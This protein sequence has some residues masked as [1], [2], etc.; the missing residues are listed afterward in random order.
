MY[1]A[2]KISQA[3]KNAAWQKNSSVIGRMS[4]SMAVMVV[5]GEAGSS[6]EPT[7]L[8]TKRVEILSQA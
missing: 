5:A 8:R 6:S 7:K 2:R 3:K 1:D 4:G